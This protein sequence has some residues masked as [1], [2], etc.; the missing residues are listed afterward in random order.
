MEKNSI[1][2][3][4][5][6]AKSI[7]LHCFSSLKPQ[8]LHWKENG[9][10]YTAIYAYEEGYKSLIYLYKGCGDIEL[11]STFL[12]R[13]LP[14]LKWRYRGYI[15]VPAPSHP[16]KI[17]AR[18]FDHVPL[19]FEGVGKGVKVVF[20]K[21]SDIKQSAQS[22][23]QRRH[24]GEHIAVLSQA[25]VRGEKVLLVDDVLTTGSTM[26]ACLGF[27]QHMGPKKI[28][29]LVLARVPLKPKHS[30]KPDF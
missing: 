12:E 3:L 25:K 18:G 13:L 14:Y 17:A 28:E 2:D 23:A 15:I 27:L 1:F 6:A 16:E 5:F 22:R 20:Q 11:C 10:P 30:S 7:C 19:M 29:V 9:V 21:T 8:Y 24:I 4:A 26:R